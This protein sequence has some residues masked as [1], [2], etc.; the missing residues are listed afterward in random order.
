VAFNSSRPDT[1]LLVVNVL[2]LEV[3]TLADPPNWPSVATDVATWLGTDYL[4]ML[5]TSFVWHNL[6]VT[7]EDY[8]GSLFGQGI[9]SSEVPGNRTVADNRLDPA[10]CAV[11]S[12]KTAVA[13]RYARGHMFCPPAITEG[14]LGD[15]ATWAPANPYFPACTA[16]ANLF[17]S[18]HSVAST[19][20]APIV[21]SRTRVALNQSPYFFPIVGHSVGAKQHW[22]R[23]RS[24][25]P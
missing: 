5:P 20:Y 23:S 18:G 14:A 15:D 9:V 6:T 25:A 3:D 17:A 8:P 13:K 7:A 16:F 4:A 2:H 19:S 24:S 1:G 12:W 22:L 10:V 11:I 21:F